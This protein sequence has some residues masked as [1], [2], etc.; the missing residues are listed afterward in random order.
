MKTRAGLLIYRLRNNRPEVLLSHHGGPLWAK[1]DVAAWSIFKGEVE[2]GEDLTQTARREFEEET[3]QSAPETHWH[4]LNPIKRKDGKVIH[5]WA[6]EGSYDAASIV[7]N[8]FTMEWPPK[9]GKIQKFP[10]NDRAEWFDLP[11]AMV[12][13]HEGQQAFIRDMVKILTDKHPG[14]ELPDL[15]ADAL[16]EKPETQTLF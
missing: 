12:K 14:T 11:T 10:E 15:D 9:S 16:P 3:G 5:A 13:L 7:S 1:K 8:T 6:A 2:E 4:E